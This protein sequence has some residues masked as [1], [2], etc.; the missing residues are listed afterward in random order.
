MTSADV[1]CTLQMKYAFSV[2]FLHSKFLQIILFNVHCRI[3][4]ANK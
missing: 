3:E 1:G 4:Q 2:K